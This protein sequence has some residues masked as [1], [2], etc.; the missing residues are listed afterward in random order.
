MIFFRQLRSHK[1]STPVLEAKTEK[2]KSFA[3]EVPSNI[4]K[5]A[6]K[7]RRIYDVAE[8]VELPRKKVEQASLMFFFK[9]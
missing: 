6:E 5:Q 8:R 1:P 9:K 3:K 7:E 2:K 4:Q